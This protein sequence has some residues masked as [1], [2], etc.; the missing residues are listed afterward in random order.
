[1]AI[2]PRPSPGDSDRRAGRARG[3]KRLV[4]A[5]L[6]SLGLLILSV[7]VPLAL[8]AVTGSLDR[9]QQWALPSGYQGWVVD[10]MCFA[11]RER[12]AIG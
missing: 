10:I 6:L 7:C 9:P 2:L 4:A 12:R 8:V 1:M 3:L 5:I 11:R